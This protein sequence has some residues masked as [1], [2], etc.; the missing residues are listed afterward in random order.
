MGGHETRHQFML[1]TAQAERAGNVDVSGVLHA[2]AFP[3]PPVEEH[4]F[5]GVAVRV[6]AAGR[7][8][9]GIVI[10]GFLVERGLEFPI[11]GQCLFQ[12]GEISS[13]VEIT[14]APIGTRVE[15]AREIGTTTV[16]IER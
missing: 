8:Q 3:A 4:A 5:A 10:G 1:A 7:G 14:T 6:A 11:V 15:T 16:A 13:A 12:G 2:M 9:L